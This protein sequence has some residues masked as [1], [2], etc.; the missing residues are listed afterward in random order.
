[1]AF[2]MRF[3]GIL[4][5]L[6]F[7][8]SVQFFASSS[9][10]ESCERK[11]FSELFANAKA[12]LVKLNKENSSRIQK[13]LRELK[14]LKNWSDKEFLKK[15]APF[16]SSEDIQAYDVKSKSLLASVE[17]FGGSGGQIDDGPDEEKCIKLNEFRILM[18]LLIKNAQDK[19]SFM[20]SKIDNEIDST[21][22]GTN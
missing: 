7:V 19:W 21:S 13:K 10:A 22:R 1:M 17:D 5:I 16:V 18:E 15:A 2:D 4:R 11:A 8:V 3:S 20:L 6:I 14:K 12:D 9:L